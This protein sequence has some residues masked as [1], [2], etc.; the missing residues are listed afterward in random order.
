[1]PASWTV[2]AIGLG[3]SIGVTVSGVWL[4]VALRRSAGAEALSGLG[5]AAGAG[6]AGGL[7]GGACGTLLAR[8]APVTGVVGDLVVVAVVAAVV[9]AVHT[10][11]VATIDRPTL[12]LL[13]DRRRLRRA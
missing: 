1:M 5:Q 8:A 4:L 11:I 13:L 12:R 2:A 3:T 6:F 7:V 9:L 10:A